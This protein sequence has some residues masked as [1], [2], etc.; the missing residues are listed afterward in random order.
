MK[1]ELSYFKIA[2]HKAYFEKGYSLTH[3]LF[4][5]IAVFGVTSNQIKETFWMVGVYTITCYFLGMIV[6]KSK[7]ISAE[8]EIQNKVNP[9]VQEMRSKI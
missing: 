7:F 3:Y 2:L 9:F 1:T 8:I 4:K 5:L 6:F